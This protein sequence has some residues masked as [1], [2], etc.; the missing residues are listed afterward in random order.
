MVSIDSSLDGTSCE[1]ELSNAFGACPPPPNKSLKIRKHSTANS[2]E[3]M[4]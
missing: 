1:A 4:E 2:S 3:K